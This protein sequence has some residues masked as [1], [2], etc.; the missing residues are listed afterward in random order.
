LITFRRR[1]AAE[2]EHGLLNNLAA[3]TSM[4]TT[5]TSMVIKSSPAEMTATPTTTATRTTTRT[6]KP[7]RPI[8]GVPATLRSDWAA[9]PAKPLSGAERP[10]RNGLLSA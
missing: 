1:G 2:T 7:K 10:R 4:T 6:S 8:A 9:R 3:P 5:P